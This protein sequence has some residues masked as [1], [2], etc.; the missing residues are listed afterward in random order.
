[1][2]WSTFCQRPAKSGRFRFGVIRHLRVGGDDCGVGILP[3]TS[4]SAY[5]GQNAVGTYQPALAPKSVSKLVRST[6][7][8]PGFLP[9]R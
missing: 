6:N 1:M 3:A 5:S 8:R 7:Y 2:P 9:W 4:E